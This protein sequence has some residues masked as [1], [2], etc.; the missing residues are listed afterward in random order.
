MF[1]IA[2]REESQGRIE[3]SGSGD[4]YLGEV[5]AQSALGTPAACFRIAQQ[6]GRIVA[7]QGLG[8]NQN[9]VVSGTQAVDFGHVLGSRDR[10]PLGG[11]IVH[12]AVGRDRGG[13][14]YEHRRNV[15]RVI[16]G[17]APMRI[18]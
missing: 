4:R 18:G 16:S 14:G 15:I 6:Q 17:R 11:V 7:A 12:V 9:G 13:E 1:G 5:G 8:A 2:L 3:L 10:Q